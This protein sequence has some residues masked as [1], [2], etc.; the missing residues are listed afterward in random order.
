[1]KKNGNWDDASLVFIMAI[2]EVGSKI[3]IASRIFGVHI[4]S[5]KNHLYGIT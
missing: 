5:L 4:T 3:Q 2:V 1:L